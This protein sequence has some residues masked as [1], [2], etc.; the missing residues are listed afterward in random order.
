MDKKRKKE[1]KVGK[2]EKKRNVIAYTIPFAVNSLINIIFVIKILNIFT[3]TSV[4]W[5]MKLGK[6]FGAKI[7]LSNIRDMF[8]W[9]ERW[10]LIPLGYMILAVIQFGIAIYVIVLFWGI[11]ND[12]N[13]IC[14]RYEGAN[15]KKSPNYLVVMLFSVITLGIYYFYWVYKQ[16]NRLWEADQNYYK[17]NIKDTGITYL[18]FVILGVFTCGI[19][20]C[21]FVAKLLNNL[22]LL[23]EAC[24]QDSSCKSDGVQ[25]PIQDRPTE[26]VED[27]DSFTVP[28]EEWEPLT[29]R[30]EGSMV[31]CS[32]IYEGAV[33]PVGAEELIIGRD[34]SIANIVIKN[35]KISR[36]HCGVRYM[37]EKG[38]YVVTDYSTNGTFYKNGQRFPAGT[39]NICRSGM[40]FVISE[41]GNEFLLK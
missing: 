14:S 22:N 11:C 2:I 13:S 39:P 28:V 3:S 21:I 31:C 1:D 15:A 17:R 5:A 10:N 16:G 36:K 4:R 29:E 20:T 27:D 23:T 12:I 33:F 37:A 6:S 26:P 35:P 32:G 38:T 7:S 41:S 30:Q 19:G 24:K 18:L 8:L 25:I 34:E 40:I 9:M